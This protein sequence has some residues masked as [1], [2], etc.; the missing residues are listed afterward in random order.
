MRKIFFIF[1]LVT[2][3]K[4]SFAMTPSK[5]IFQTMLKNPILIAH[6]DGY[7]SKH[8]FVG[9]NVYSAIMHVEKNQQSIDLLVGYS[10][11]NHH[12]REFFVGNVQKNI[13]PEQSIMQNE[14][15]LQKIGIS[16]N[17]FLSFLQSKYPVV[18][19]IS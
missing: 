9:T 14:E 2:F 11:Q 6:S 15:Q 13:L 10:V 7:N 19:W 17:Q 4:P 18:H 3:L 8:Q 5:K 1:T 12:I 16:K